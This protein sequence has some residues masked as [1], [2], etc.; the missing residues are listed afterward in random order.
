MAKL[1]NFERAKIIKENLKLEVRSRKWFQN[2]F[3]IKNLNQKLLFLGIFDSMQQ[4][5][6]TINIYEELYGTADKWYPPSIL[7]SAGDLEPLPFE[8]TLEQKIITNR[9]LLHPEGS[10][11]F[12]LT[13]KGGSGKSTFLNVIKQLFD[14][15]VSATP[16]NKLGEDFLLEQ[17]LKKRLICADEI[18]AEDLNNGVIKTI[19]DHQQITVNKKFGSVYETMAQSAMIFSC[20]NPPKLNLN[21]SG[22]MRRLVYYEMNSVIKDPNPELK[23]LRLTRAQLR[24]VVCDVLEMETVPDWKSFF[25]K[26]TRRILR[27]NNNVWICAEFENYERYVDICMRKRLKPFSEPNWRSICLLFE[28]WG[29]IAGA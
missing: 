27:E 2:G 19:S 22:M 10:E 12:I 20:N 9:L 4:L 24:Q 5:N 26:Q 15:D 18:N 23:D 28:E 21:D 13:G 25:E 14:D 7:A 1:T 29:C 11:F 17:A 3:E 16:L 8:L 6:D